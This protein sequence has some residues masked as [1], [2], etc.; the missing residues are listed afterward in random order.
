M[1]DERDT[2]NT[3]DDTPRVAPLSDLGDF[4]IAEGFPDPRG[5]DVITSDGMK[6]GNVHDLIVDT[7]TMRTRYLD[8]R[9]DTDLADEGDDRDVLI[10]VGAAKLDDPDD[11]VLLGN[12]TTAQLAALPGYGHGAITR[13][14]ENSVLSRMPGSAVSPPNSGNDYYASRHFD[15]SQLAAGRRGTKTDADQTTNNTTRVVRSEEE[16]DISKR[17]VQA[18]QVEVHK[19]VETEHVRQPVMVT[20]EEITVERRPVSADRLPD[21]TAAAGVATA[22]AAGVQDTGNEI[23]IPIVEEEIVVETRQV[24]KEELVITKHLVTE[25]QT[26]EADLKKERIDIDRNMARDPSGTD[27]PVD[28][29]SRS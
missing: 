1:T 25:E 3:P 17:Q 22:G 8:V 21:G 14:Y 16:L 5:W 24:V 12:M 15:D 28:P 11:R 26:V 9:L 10:P 19:T 2:R 27:R 13:E 6:A 20:R 18:G 29:S 23:R 7:G 4:Q